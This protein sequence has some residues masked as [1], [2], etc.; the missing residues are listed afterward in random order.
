MQS[1]DGH[2][3]TRRSIAAR[4]LRVR[5][6]VRVESVDGPAARAGLREGDVILSIDNTEIADSKQFATVAAKAEKARAV[7]VLVR[8]GDR[9]GEL[10]LRVGQGFLGHDHAGGALAL[11]APG[12]TWVTPDSYFSVIAPELAAAILKRPPSAAPATAD[13]LG[14]RPQDLVALGVARGIVG[15]A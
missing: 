8:R 15:P 7:S 10:R 6:G 4:E 5:G 11:A 13:Q 1:V 14:I 3:V 2:A 9:L 12:N